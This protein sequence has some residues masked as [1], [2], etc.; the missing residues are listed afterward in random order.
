MTICCERLVIQSGRSNSLVFHY[1]LSNVSDV[2]RSGFNKGVSQICKLV[3]H[4]SDFGRFEITPKLVPG[5]GDRR[6]NKLVAVRGT[7]HLTESLGRNI[8]PR[9]TVLTAI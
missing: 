7:S 8:A 5:W 2:S 3:L 9:D 1:Q 4:L 6:E